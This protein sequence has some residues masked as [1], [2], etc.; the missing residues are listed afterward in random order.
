MIY[1]DL[2]AAPRAGRS[3]LAPGAWLALVLNASVLAV[4][5]DRPRSLAALWVASLVAVA[6]CRPG[7]RQ[8]RVLAIFTAVGA[9]AFVVGQGLFYAAVPRTV[10]GTIVPVDFPLLG[11]ATGG[12][13]LYREG[14]VHGL[15]QSLRMAAMLG[16]GLAACW[17]TRPQDL[18]LALTRLRVPYGLAFMTVTAFRFV[19][20]VA[21]ESL[22]VAA[23][24][25]L[26]GWRPS[27]RKPGAWIAV[28]AGRLRAVLASAVRRSATLALAVQGRGF[29]PGAPRT[30]FRET[31]LGAAD[32][33]AIAA[34]TLL[35]TAVAA[36]K[37]LHALHLYDLFHADALRWVYVFAREAL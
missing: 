17:A 29:T 32:L 25:R 22:T 8:L 9:W 18:I 24:Q 26:R 28:W 15:V 35:T 31:R 10:L 36:A 6:V 4:L 12:V 20:V 27:W 7:P 13:H 23:V 5:L 14:L 19:P 37:L 3:P 30:S 16:F 21:R 11:P 34:A 1:D 2:L 33:A